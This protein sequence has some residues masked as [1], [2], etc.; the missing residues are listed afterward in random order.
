MAR[1]KQTARKATGGKAPR[2]ALAT[3]A[4]S[5]NV[6]LSASAS[7]A[8]L[9]TRFLEQVPSDESEDEGDGGAAAAAASG[10]ASSAL[11][12][13]LGSDTR[14]LG[15]RIADSQR[16][17]AAR[18]ASGAAGESDDEGNSGDDDVM[19]LEPRPPT[20]LDERRSRAKARSTAAAATAAAAAAASKQSRRRTRA[21]AAAKAGGAAAA[22]SA[23]PAPASAAGRDAFD[24]D[25]DSDGGPT[26]DIF[27]APWLAWPDD[28]ARF[29]SVDDAATFRRARGQRDLAEALVFSPRTTSAKRTFGALSTGGDELESTASYSSS[30]S[31]AAA[32]A[33][34]A[35]DPAKI[36]RL[37]AAELG[38]CSAASSS[39]SSQPHCPV[40]HTPSSASSVSVAASSSAAAVSRCYLSRVSAT[41]H[42]WEC[43]L[44]GCSEAERVTVTHFT[45]QHDID[46][47]KKCMLWRIHTEQFDLDPQIPAA[48]SPDQF[49]AAGRP[50]ITAREFVVLTANSGRSRKTT[51]QWAIQPVALSRVVRS[52][53]HTH[54]PCCGCV[55]PPRPRPPLPAH[56]RCR[57]LVPVCSQDLG[58]VQL[59]V[60]AHY[61]SSTGKYICSGILDDSILNSPKFFPHLARL[62]LKN[63]GGLESKSITCT[64]CGPG[65]IAC[66][67]CTDPNCPHGLC[68]RCYSHSKYGAAA[69]IQWADVAD[70]KIPLPEGPA[71]AAC[72]AHGP[73]PNHP[74]LTVVQRPFVL[75]TFQGLAAED[76]RVQATASRMHAQDNSFSTG[77]GCYPLIFDHRLLSKIG[78]KERAR[79]IA[80]QA[81]DIPCSTL[82]LTVSAHGVEGLGYSIGQDHYTALQLLE[83]ILR[84]IARAF[85][86]APNRSPT[87]EVVVLFDCCDVQLPLWVT[88]LSALPPADAFTMISFRQPLL[89]ADIPGVLA[90]FVRTF[91]NDFL[92]AAGYTPAHCLA[93]SITWQFERAAQPMLIPS[94]GAVPITS[95]IRPFS[96]FLFAPAAPGSPPNP[97][98]AGSPPPA[99]LAPAAVAAVLAT[100]PPALTATRRNRLVVEYIT[101]LTADQRIDQHVDL[102][103]STAELVS[104]LN[105]IAGR[106]SDG[107]DFPHYDGSRGSSFNKS[108]KKEHWR[109]ER[110]EDGST[111]YH[112]RDYPRSD[113]PSPSSC[114]PAS[115][116]ALD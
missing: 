112:W 37:A 3:K 56:S 103:D 25:L 45:C 101:G 99:L 51:K 72:T 91:T 104:A 69:G 96:Q 84:P 113:S 67:F 116:T 34:T 81:Q 43:D 42:S 21:T 49:D 68:Y 23:A 40:F 29:L 73:L 55:R 63:L 28:S 32:A 16:A 83:N 106:V 70:Y 92:R 57:A 26:H 88:L 105:V 10:A 77:L 109:R 115:P 52:V 97:A 107:A 66:F 62:W 11:V 82:I 85:R 47:C 22:A 54:C 41:S 50:V 87:A 18:A 86:S 33:A 59:V 15:V 111:A 53:S 5:R 9:H 114:S 1:T 61:Y 39:G 44:C 95:F 8:E 31:A 58:V 98:A 13:T 6:A 74:D 4:F 78:G 64:R 46:I 65:F 100:P 110:F 75:I 90:T 60:R 19:I 12:H 14:G 94:G 2:K 80:K 35:L 108:F 36:A 20:S 79:D 17:A 38:G 102:V 89:L 24:P 71:C 7:S 76:E 93:A 27:A 30:G 48:L